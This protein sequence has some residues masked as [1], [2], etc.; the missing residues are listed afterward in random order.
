M[1]QASLGRG[2]IHHAGGL[3]VPGDWVH[4]H[5]L[6]SQLDFRIQNQQGPVGVE[7]DGESLLLEGLSLG[8]FS[9]NIDRKASGK[10]AAASIGGIVCCEHR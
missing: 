8:R 2:C 3:I 1:G 9:A 7:G 4:Q 5:Y 10:P 6:L